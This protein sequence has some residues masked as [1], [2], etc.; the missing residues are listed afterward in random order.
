MQ[1]GVCTTDFPRMPLEALFA[2]IASFGFS[3]IQ[4][5]FDS[6]E[7]SGFTADGENE[8]PQS[9]DPALCERIARCSKAHGLSIEAINGTYNMAHPSAAVRAEGLRRF[10]RLADAAVRMACPIITLC[11]GSRNTKHLWQTHPDNQ[12]ASAWCDMMEGMRALCTIAEARGLLMAIETEA[13]NVIDTVAKARRVL[14]E[15]NSPAL[16]MI[17]DCANLFLPGEAHSENV[18]P[19]IREAFE[20]FGESI[21]LAHGKDIAES[22]G[23]EFCPTGD[24]I[25]DYPF[26]L[27]Q[28]Q[29]IGYEGKMMLHGIYEDEAMARAVALMRSLPGIQ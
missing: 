19:R 23:V 8:I 7:E 1:L 6:I 11:S 27:D 21:A 24:G 3:G 20:G 22:D 26:F 14:D 28:L 15:A 9:F 16:K 4:F 25:I 5:A 10:E 29:T 13:S 2:K 17:I 12:T 18:R